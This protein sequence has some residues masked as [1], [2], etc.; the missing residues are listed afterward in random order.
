MRLVVI[1]FLANKDEL[2]T[3]KMIPFLKP[4]QSAV[5]VEQQQDDDAAN[6][7]DAPTWQMD[8]LCSISPPLHLT[9]HQHSMLSSTQND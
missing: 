5:R 2:I 1:I 4:M 3:V 6:V 8:E 7:E 9:Q